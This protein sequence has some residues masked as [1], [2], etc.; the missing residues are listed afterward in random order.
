[1]DIRF[2]QF[3]LNENRAYLGQRIGDVLNAM[4][5]FSQDESGLGT[6]HQV[7]SANQIVNAIR[8]ILHSPW[9]KEEDKNLQALQKVGVAIMQAIEEK[10]ELAEVMKGATA[11]LE[12]VVSGMGVTTNQLGAPEDA[13]QPEDEKG[14]EGVGP[15]PES[16]KKP[17]KPPEGQNQ[18]APPNP[19][20]SPPSQMPPAD[21]PGTPGMPLSGP[22]G[23]QVPQ[24]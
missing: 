16:P 18:Q 14:E 8:G 2:K 21:V 7:R 1:M 9:G 4:H 19:Q 6:R 15:K 10:N 23:Q 20:Q 22:P 13:A 24:L 12:G 11:E 17:E 3:L 5:D